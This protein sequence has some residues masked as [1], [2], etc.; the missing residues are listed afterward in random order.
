[1]TLSLPPP[2]SFHFLVLVL[3]L[4]FL[5]CALHSLP[6]PHRSGFHHPPRRRTAS[7]SPPVRLATPC[8]LLIPFLLLLR[9]IRYSRL[10][11]HHLHIPFSRSSLPTLNSKPR[12]VP[13]LSNDLLLM[14]YQLNPANR[15]CVCNSVEWLL[16]FC[17]C[18]NVCMCVRVCACICTYVRTTSFAGM[19]E[20]RSEYTYL[21]HERGSRV[22]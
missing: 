17:E 11:S 15:L 9:V 6:F 2:S 21:P 5:S 14:L 10:H 19:Y 4:L 22:G 8:F 1:M 13:H 18:I 16:A 12:C 7:T 3:L 20:C